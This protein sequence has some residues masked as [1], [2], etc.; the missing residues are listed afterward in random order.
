MKRVLLSIVLLLAAGFSFAQEK[1]V[2]EAKSLADAVKPNFTEAEKLIG[3]A[4][5]NPE[6]KNQA[7]TCYKK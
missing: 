3:E 2:K 6:T 1:N 5:E 4:L 7:N